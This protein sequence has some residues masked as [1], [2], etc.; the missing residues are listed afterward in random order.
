MRW[1]AIVL[2]AACGASSRPHAGS[3][4]NTEPV[5]DAHTQRS[6]HHGS[7]PTPITSL[8]PDVVLSTIR[9]RYLTGVER[10]YQRHLKMHGGRD[11]RVLLSFT[12]DPK[13]RARDS[14]AHG[15]AAQVDGCIAAQ[16]ARWRFPVPRDPG[17]AP[18][19]AHFALGLQ[20][21]AN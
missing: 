17:G 5:E 4:A 20:L 14:T 2:V 6:G 19:E 13:G 8:T 1:L 3:P 21:G 12:V 7:G 18:I 9:G 10:C 15:L 16:V 11:A